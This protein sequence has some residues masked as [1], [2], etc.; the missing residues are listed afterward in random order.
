VVK[1]MGLDK[2]I[3]P[4]FLHPGP[5]YGGS[6]FPKDTRALAALGVRHGAPQAIVEA[7]I[8]VNLSQRRLLVDK[9]VAALGVVSETP[10]AV[11]GLAFKPNTDDVREAPALY[12][13]RELARA[14]ARI[15]AFDPVAGR[16]AAEALQDVRDRLSFPA[17]AHEALAGAQA[18]VI[19][20]EW[21]EFRGLDLERVRQ[22]MARPLLID[23]RNVLD[24]SQTRA[25][26]FE[27]IC[28]GRQVLAP[29]AVTA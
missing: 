23:A 14:G 26:G 24:P 1:G 4:K 12:V 7:A 16:A 19:M 29:Q 21:N 18:A 25:K 20:T 28:T 8:E 15:R 11:L 3:G 22:L 6:C 2:R 9:I 13:C 27:Y 5:G 10:V 17:D